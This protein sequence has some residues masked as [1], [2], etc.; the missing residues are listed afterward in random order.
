MKTRLFITSFLL[1]I[2]NFYAIVQAETGCKDIAPTFSATTG[3]TPTAHRWLYQ[4]ENAS[5]SQILATRFDLITMDYSK[6]GSDEGR[7][8]RQEIQKLQAAGKVVLAYLSIGGAEDYRYYLKKQWKTNKPCWLGAVMADW[9][10]NYN[11]HYWS[12]SWQQIILGYLDKII[13]AGF[14]G[15][16]LDI[17]DGFE[18]WSDEDNEDGLVL[19]E[20]E[21]AKR[22]INFVKR[23]AYH[24][25]VVR[26]KPKFYIFPQN[27]SNLLAHDKDGSYLRT[28]SGIGV[29][30][31]FYDETTPHPVSESAYRIQYLDKIKAAGKKVL[32]VDYVDDKSGYKERNK[33]RIRRFRR[34][35]LR[36]GYMPYVGASDRALDSI[37]R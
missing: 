11:T 25:R 13:A 37:N 3:I 36:K 6:D 29:E 8:T 19:Q 9:E 10:G 7:Y 5:I 17:V 22:M 14:D 35:V 1:V 2:I 20:A 18:Y 21:A 12:N 4:L 31:L 30:D 15:V 33:R 24:A 28:I 34:K 27:G 23:I 26:H 32:V 16:Y